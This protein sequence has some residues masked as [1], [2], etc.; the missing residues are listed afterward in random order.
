VRLDA[1]VAPGVKI[2][3]ETDALRAV[4][5]HVG[6]ARGAIS[7]DGRMHRNDKV[8]VFAQLKAIDDIINKQ[9]QLELFSPAQRA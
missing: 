2:P 1:V 3:V 8:Y 9:L 5:L 6:R 4:R 7:K